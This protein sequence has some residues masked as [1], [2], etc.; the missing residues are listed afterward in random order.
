MV[1]RHFPEERI[2]ARYLIAAIK[3]DRLVRPVTSKS[4]ASPG[5]NIAVAPTR[6][7]D[8][9]IRLICC[10]VKQPIGLSLVDV[11]GQGVHGDAKLGH[12]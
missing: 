12:L 11:D 1:Q 8:E 7:V 3:R 6:R 2:C 5:R 4:D 10:S 9:K